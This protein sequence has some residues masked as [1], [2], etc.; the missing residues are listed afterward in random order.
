MP[1]STPPFQ[2]VRVIKNQQL[3][4]NMQRI[5][6]QGDCIGQ[7]SEQD[8]SGYIKLLFHPNGGTDL[9]LLADG[10]RPIL[11][12]YT[13]RSV[14][15][16][17]Q[18]IDIDLVRHL[19]SDPADQGFA[20]PWAMNAQVGDVINIR[21]PGTLKPF[22]L[23][24]DWFFLVADM[25]ALPACSVV[26]SRLPEHAKGYVLVQVESEADQQP[27]QLPPAMEVIWLTSADSLADT[28]LSLPWLEGQASVWS[29]CEF[30]SMR[31]IRRYF[32]QQK[33]VPAENSYIS[34][35]WKKGANEEMHKQIKKQ[36]AEQ[37]GL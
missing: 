27:L 18:S 12:T 7:F 4:P 21:G 24:A 22:A 11:R 29:A 17:N 33:Q 20:S 26:A 19:S 14:D 15:L 5:T 1:N 28:A 36:E 10:E 25:T 9:S 8:A 16:S 32:R 23:D 35:Y 6:L 2:P 37:L 34:S 30:E 3:T 31:Q 13:I